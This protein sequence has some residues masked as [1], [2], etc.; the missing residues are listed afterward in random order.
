MIYQ[1][2][3]KAKCNICDK[4]NIIAYRKYLKNYNNY[5]FYS[6]KS[7]TEYKTKKTKKEKYGDE[8][9]R[10]YD[11]YLLTMNTKYKCNHPMKCDKIKEKLKKTRVDRGLEVSID[12]ID[13]FNNYRK[14]VNMETRK[15]KFTLFNNWDGY[16][17]YDNEF[18]N[19]NLNLHFNNIAYPT[20]DHKIS[21][22][23]GFQNKIDPIS[24]G[25]INNLCITKRYINCRKS[26][27]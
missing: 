25:S 21:I 6:C 3:V 16:D 22:Y 27:K 8:N 9:Y 14:I 1:K 4:E 26:I 7:C 23:K 19:N 20:I 5:N 12:D 18:I 24:I 17:Y 13:N 10:N 15:N 2:V 11:K